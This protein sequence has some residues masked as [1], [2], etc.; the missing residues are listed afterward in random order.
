MLHSCQLYLT[1]L[2]DASCEM[3]LVKSPKPGTANHD[4]VMRNVQGLARAG[5]RYVDLTGGNPLMF[6]G[7]PEAIRLANQFGMISSL[8]VS[9]PL[10]S[11][12]GEDIFGLPSQLQFSIDGTPAFHD[13]NRGAGFYQHIVNGLEMAATL[14]PGRKPAKLIFTTLP[15][16][17]GNINIETFRSVLALARRFPNTLV[18]VNPVFGGQYSPEEERLLRWFGRQAY[19]QMSR[20]KLRFLRQGGNNAKNPFCRAT[21]TSAA[22]T[23]DSKLRLPC[24]H[25][26]QCEV[27]LEEG[28]AN[29]LA[30][31]ER[32]E[33]L[34]YQGR[35]PCCEGC[36]IWCYMMPSIAS[37]HAL[38]FAF[39]YQQMMVAGQ[40][41]RDSLLRF[42][43]QYWGSFPNCH[44]MK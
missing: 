20:G 5:V 40:G 11:R 17:G 16:H 22:I 42:C 13:A 7:L 4:A 28:L 23:A 32:R 6:E 10:I 1:T 15:G 24:Y 38:R 39:P 14:R 21:S 29:A 33:A 27:P 36:S 41:I 8:T 18:S 44:P 35:L 30:S 2:C 25:R 19:V 43:G 31:P 3:C 26:A 9:G 12:R 34:K 37:L